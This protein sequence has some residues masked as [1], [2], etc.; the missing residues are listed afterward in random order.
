MY[1]RDVTF[2]SSGFYPTGIQTILDIL[3]RYGER[4]EDTKVAEL[5]SKI[6]AVPQ[7]VQGFTYL[8][9]SVS[10][11]EQISDAFLECANDH[12]EASIASEIH[13]TLRNH[14]YRP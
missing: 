2:I 10:E 8:R 13:E 4:S 3:S 1:V 5:V 6:N 9:L 7:A 12:W 11:W 14:G